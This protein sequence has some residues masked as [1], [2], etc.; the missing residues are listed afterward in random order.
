MKSL[1]ESMAAC[2][3][4]LADRMLAATRDPRPGMRRGFSMRASRRIAR[5]IRQSHELRAAIRE[6]Q[7]NP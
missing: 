6:S 5:S 7:Q 3:S 4:V 2:V 1:R